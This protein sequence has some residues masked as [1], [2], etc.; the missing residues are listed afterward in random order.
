MPNFGPFLV[1]SGADFAVFCR[2]SSLIFF[3]FSVTQQTLDQ[4]IGV[5]IPGGSQMCSPHTLRARDAGV[6]QP[7]LHHT[8]NIE[9][10]P[11]LSS[12]PKEQLTAREGS[13]SWKL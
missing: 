5:R 3:I 9:S 8:R 2:G 12:R 10:E 4:H 13:V 6:G 11:D 1:R 7:Y